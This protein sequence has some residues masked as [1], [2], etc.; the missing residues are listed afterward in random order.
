MMIRAHYRGRAFDDRE[1]R[2]MGDAFAMACHVIRAA[3]SSGEAVGV[4]PALQ[5][6]IASTVLEVA[7]FGVM[8]S[9]TMAQAA[10]DRVW[11]AA[12]P[13]I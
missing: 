9:G 8:D 10:I 13:S 11:S 1:T 7:A 3:H 5:R 4:S 6:D 2:I 12:P